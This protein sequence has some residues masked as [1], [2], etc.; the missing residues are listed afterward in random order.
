MTATQINT[1]TPTTATEN[2]RL[3]AALRGVGRKIDAGDPRQVKQAATQLVSQVFFAPM[4][5]EM[6]KTTFG[7]KF[8]SGGR[9]EEAF[10]EQLD[11][12]VADAVAGTGTRPLVEKLAKKISDK[13]NAHELPGPQAAWDA[14]LRVLDDAAHPQD[15]NRPLS[16]AKDASAAATPT[17][18][19]GT[20]Q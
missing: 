8:A 19:T 5:Q 3:L 12:R 9:T 10:G 1:T 18:T 11:Q 17:K 7:E 15:A 6:R 20:V 14:V 2:T 16:A 4:L 13:K